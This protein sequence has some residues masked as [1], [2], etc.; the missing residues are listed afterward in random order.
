MITGSRPEHIN[1]KLL[2]H[3]ARPPRVEHIA[4][5]VSSAPSIWKLPPPAQYSIE[6][7]AAGLGGSACSNGA[8]DNQVGTKPRK[9]GG[10]ISYDTNGDGFIDSLDTN[11][12]GFIDTRLGSNGI[13]IQKSTA[14]GVP[15]D[16]DGDDTAARAMSGTI[17]EGDDRDEVSV[18]LESSI[19]LLVGQSMEF[20]ASPSPEAGPDV[21]DQQPDDLPGLSGTS[22]ITNSG[23]ATDDSDSSVPVS[24]PVSIHSTRLSA[25]DNDD[26]DANDS[27]LVEEIEVEAEDYADDNAC[28]SAAVFGSTRITRNPGASGNMTCGKSN[29][30]TGRSPFAWSIESMQ[31]NP[32]TCIGLPAVQPE[33]DAQCTC[34][35][36]KTLLATTEEHLAKVSAELLVSQRENRR[37]EAAQKQAQRTEA[38]LARLESQMKRLGIPIDVGV[39]ISDGE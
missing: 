29:I 10:A 13:C 20:E 31:S 27:A 25:G 3:W 1:G 26:S 12:D 15:A 32:P 8:T 22:A 6:S 19:E 30:S 11:G 33:A 14:T 5:F 21:I 18:E 36:L 23:A 38:R 34:A 39:H 16:G 37:L 24:M 7:A 9:S 4:Q 28:R 2:G 17:G 35:E